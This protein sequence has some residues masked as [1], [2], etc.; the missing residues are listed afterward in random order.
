MNWEVL[1]EK[2]IN[3]KHYYWH[4]DNGVLLKGDCLEVMKEIPKECIDLVLTDPPYNIADSAKLTKAGGEIKS[5]K[6]AWGSRFKDKWDSNEE[7]ATWILDVLAETHKIL[8]KSGSLILFLDRKYGGYFAHK[9]EDDLKFKYRNKIYFEKLNPLP[10]FRKNNYR[11]C[12]EEALW[13]SRSW[14]G[15]YCIN[16]ISQQD[17][18]QVFKGNIGKKTSKHP[19]EKYAWMIEPLINRHSNENDIIIDPFMGSGTVA[20]ASEKLNRR[21][22]GIELNEEYCQII[23]QRTMQKHLGDFQ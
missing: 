22:I 19:T 6:D 23:K 3:S 1:K 16:F 7:Y 13:F 20:A 9:I 18:K 10:Q 17:M 15:E 2:L 11:S 21:W 4:T 5:T 8:N 12:I 14:N